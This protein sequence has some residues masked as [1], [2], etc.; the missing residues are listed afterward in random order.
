VTHWSQFA[1]IKDIKKEMFK[2]LETHFPNAAPQAH[3]A[4]LNAPLAFKNRSSAAPAFNRSKTFFLALETPAH[5]WFLYPIVFWL[6][7][8]RGMMLL[9][10]EVSL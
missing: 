2:R 7:R 5:P 8:G 10:P 1:D 4:P 6:W 3:S 9:V